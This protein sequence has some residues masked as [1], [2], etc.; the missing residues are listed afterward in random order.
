MQNKFN[1]VTRSANYEKGKNKYA[2]VINEEQLNEFVKAVNFN[3]ESVLVNGI[4]LYTKKPDYVKIFKIKSEWLAK[5]DDEIKDLLRKD[6]KMLFDGRLNV[7]IL[8][9]HG[10][11]VTGQYINSGLIEFDNQRGSIIH[12]SIQQ[13]SKEKFEDGY[14]SDA[15]LSAFKEINDII[16]KDYY[17]IVDKEE[18]GT[19]LMRKAFAHQ[20]PIFKLT[21][22]STESLKSIQQGYMDIFAG[23]M[24]GIRN[25]LAHANIEIDEDDA[26]EKIVIASHLMKMWQNRIE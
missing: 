19:S 6:A 16:K 12:N 25:P 4:R 17:K 5:T 20:Q 21:D 11:E 2:T 18:D 10:Q 14:F 7:R 1:V 9:K 3:A 23:V 8:R 15:V 22:L 26:W 24:M 13:V